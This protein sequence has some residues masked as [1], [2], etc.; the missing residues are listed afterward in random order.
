M[1][2]NDNKL[3]N[4]L[5]STKDKIPNI[6]KSGI[7]C[8]TCSVC[9]KKYYGQTKRSIEVR[10]KDHIQCIRLNHP[11]KSAIASHVLVDGHDNVNKE[12]L[13]LL[14]QVFDERRLDAYEAYYI[15]KD[16][17]ALNQDTGNISSCLFK[18]IN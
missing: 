18:L 11:Y 10:F 8:Y 16:E 2:R 9:N 12:N 14:K 4:L 7:Y 13:E 5:G 3:S 6:H 15:Q 1:Y 17:D